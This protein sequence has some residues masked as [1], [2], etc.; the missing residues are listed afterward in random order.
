MN[1]YFVGSRSLFLDRGKTENV[2][3]ERKINQ[4]LGTEGVTV[5]I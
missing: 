3:Q 2:P 4:T 1:V 5:D